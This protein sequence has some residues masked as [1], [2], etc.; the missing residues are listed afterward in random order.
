[1]VEQKRTGSYYTPPVIAKF[2]CEHVSRKLIGKEISVL[3]PSAGDGVFVSEIGACQLLGTQALSITAIEISNTEAGKIENIHVPNHVS[4]TVVNEDFLN[5]QDCCTEKFDLVIGNPPYIKLSYLT[6]SQIRICKNINSAFDL[7]LVS[8]VKNIWSSF[9]LS[10][11]RLLKN[12]GIVA[13][14]LPAEFLQVN[15]AKPIRDLLLREFERVEIL[16]FNE[17]VFEQC[18]G[19]DT[20]IVI[21]ERQSNEKGLFFHNVSNFNRIGDNITFVKHDSY[22]SLKWTSHV[23]S[24]EQVNLLE[25]LS[26]QLPSI[27]ELCT[28]KTGIVSAANNFFIIN[29]ETIEDLEIPNFLYKGII[30]KSSLVPKGN[31]VSNELVTDLAE[32]NT[33]CYLLS[34]S[35]IN[36]ASFPKLVDYIKYG[37][38]LSLN[39]RYKM[40]K[41]NRWF[42]VPGISESSPVLFF[43]RSH[44]CPRF[45]LNETDFLATDSA[46]LV[47]PK[48]GVDPRSLVFCFYNSLT[49]AMAEIQ[50]RY[51]GGGVLELTPSEFKGLPLPMSEIN[52]EDFDNLS[53]ALS[54][55]QE[56][57]RLLEKNDSKLLRH[58][59][60]DISHHELKELANIRE[61]LVNRR[62]RL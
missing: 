11:I 56:F 13:F 12:D 9:L 1:M 30:Q 5:Y 53:G 51:Y 4:I 22:S 21:A 35:G 36:I 40:Q 50:G 14:V 43:K 26:G 62:Q 15:Y 47:Y 7:E 10:S 60:P 37:E 8:G 44:K 59:F 20:V 57:A 31:V 54:S 2:L 23:L 28:S 41:R 61:Q 48:L 3:E 49:L 24:K 32:R 38:S 19:Q 27:S 6:D 17:L 39:E 58:Y 45:V 46:Y 18:K 33:P 25:K 16:T 55:D 34:L 52:A 42:D 29:R